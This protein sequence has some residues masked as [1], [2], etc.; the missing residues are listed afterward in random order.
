M[1]LHLKLEDETFD[2]Y[3]I[4]GKNFESEDLEYYV[5][6]NGKKTDEKARLLKS[7]ESIAA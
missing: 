5:S 7:L 3:H 1:L 2:E 4:V 6:V